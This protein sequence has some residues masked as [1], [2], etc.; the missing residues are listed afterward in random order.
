M[1]ERLWF[2]ATAFAV[3]LLTACSTAP[4]LTQYDLGIAPAGAAADPPLTTSVTRADFSA[5]AWLDSSAIV[6]RLAYGDMNQAQAYA[7]S[8][9][10]AA[11]ASL[12]SQ[13]LHERLTA[14]APAGENRASDRRLLVELDEFSQ[15]F[16][17]PEKSHVLI[18]ARATLTDAGPRGLIAQ[19]SFEVQLP[20]PTPNATGA[21]HGLRDAAEELISEVLRWVAATSTSADSSGPAG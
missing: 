9:W 20:A 2:L 16:D 19:R 15:V 1:H 4:V 5:P 12:L 18:R 11:P 8:R 6:Y 17:S 13:R 10:V 7:H 3:A 14:L 21:A